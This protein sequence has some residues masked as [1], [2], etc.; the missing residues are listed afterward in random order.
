METPE[1]FDEYSP[2]HPAFKS[3]DLLDG[4]NN[5]LGGGGGSGRNG[6]ITP[7]GADVSRKTDLSIFKRPSLTRRP[8]SSGFPERYIGLDNQTCERLKRIFG[9]MDGTPSS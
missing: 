4:C 1:C 2:Y 6:R 5:E 9:R 7:R 3:A 8:P